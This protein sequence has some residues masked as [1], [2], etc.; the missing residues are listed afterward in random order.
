MSTELLL[1]TFNL[2]VEIFFRIHIDDACSDNFIALG[3]FA[4]FTSYHCPF[5]IIITVFRT[6]H[7]F[8]ARL[9]L[10]RNG[11]TAPSNA[12][13]LLRVFCF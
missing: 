1:Q 6:A 12:S 2:T 7:G 10:S 3:N 8:C 11:I 13:F 5:L 9:N 4:S